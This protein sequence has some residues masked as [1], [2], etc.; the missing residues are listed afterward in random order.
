MRSLVPAGA[1]C[2]DADV[3]VSHTAPRPFSLPEWWRGAPRALTED[4]FCRALREFGGAE[5]RLGK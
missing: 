5:Q 2:A 1:S 4:A 3:R